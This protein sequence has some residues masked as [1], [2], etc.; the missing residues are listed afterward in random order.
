M[1]GGELGGCKETIVLATEPYTY[2]N[3]IAGMPNG[4]KTVYART[5][6]N[7]RAPRAGIIASLDVK[8]TAMDSWCNGDCAVAL[9][10]IGGQNTVVVSLYLDI[11]SSVQPDWLDDLMA[12]IDKKGYPVIIGVDS[13]AHSSLF[14]PDN[15]ARGNDFE[16]FV[17]QYGLNIENIGTKPTFEIRRGNQLVQTHIDVT[18]S[19]GLSA[20][21][22]RN[23]R[24]SQDYNASDHN[25]IL[26]EIYSKKPEP[27]LVRPWGKADWPLFKQTLSNANYRIPQDMSMK[28]LDQ[29]VDR[30][31]T[32]L[33]GALD[34]A[35]PIIQ[36]QPKIGN[37]HWATEKHDKGKSR[38]NDLYK[39]AKKTGSQAD[40]DAYK[41]ADKEFKRMC[42]NDKN[43]AWRKYKECI[44][45][46]KE[47]ASLAKQ[48]Q[49][50]ERRDINV[51]SKPD[52][53]ST[54]PGTETINLLTETH[55]PAATDTKHVTYN[56]RR[57]ISL[58]NL[59]TKYT[60]W[61]DRHK[62]TSALQGFEKKKS[63]GPDGLKPLVFEHLPNEFISTLE[64]IY[65]SAIHLGYM[66]K[67]W[68][69]T[70]VIFISKPGKESYDTPKSFRP[71]S[72]SNYLL[73]GLERLVGWRMDKAL[74]KY[75]IHEKQHGFLSGK[76]TESAIS[77][78]VNY[79]EKYVMTKQHCAGVFLDISAAFDSIKPGHVRQA[80][81]KHGG[82]PEMVQW[83]FNYITHRDIEITMH[84]VTRIFTTG[85]GFPQGGV[86]SAKFWLIAF[87][88]AIQ[89]INRYNIEGNGYADDCSAL[90]GGRR[91]DHALKKLQKMLDDLT[92]WGKTCGL[93]F[94]PD[95]S[96][97]VIF[98]RRH[99]IPPFKLKI[100]GKNIEYRTEVRYLGVLLD[101]KL[102]WKP[103]IEEKLIK[104]KQYLGKVANM[105]RNNWGPKPMLMRWAYIG[106]VRPMLCYGS[107]IWGHRAPEVMAKLRRINRMAI[108]TFANF[109][110][111]TPTTALEVMLD[112]K[113][114]HLFCIQEAL[115]A[116]VRLDRV[117]DFGWHGTSHT[118]NHAISHMG[119]LQNKMDLYGLDPQSVDKRSEVRWNHK[120]KINRDSFDGAAKHRRLSQLNVYTDGSKI[121]G[122]TG[123]GVTVY[124]GKKVIEDEHYKLPDGT[125]VFQAEVAAMAKAADLLLNRSNLEIRFV[126]IFVD[127]QAAIR[128]VGNNFISSNVVAMAIDNLNKLA[129][130]AKSVSIVWIPAHKGHEGNERADGL[131]KLGANSTDV[132][133]VLQI[134][135]PPATMKARIKEK[136]HEEW[137]EEW[138]R[139]NIAN[140][141][142]T[143]YEDLNVGKAKYVYKLARLELGRFVRIIT[144]H[145]NL[146]FFQT[147][148]GLQGDP[149]CRF[150]GEGGETLM[151]L[152]NKCPRFMSAREDIFLD[153]IPSR[154][155]KWSVRD[156]LDFSYTPGINEAYEGS[157]D[158]GDPPQVMED[159]LEDSLGLDWLEE[160]DADVTQV[161]QDVNNN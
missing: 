96:V 29:L 5:G 114:L 94:N 139:Q 38:V 108:N 63:P 156:L 134:K 37:S 111:S 101:S 3:V 36:V 76:S 118:K 88:Y 126:K 11:K 138:R 90:A 110:K 31:Y 23:W 55:F 77:N 33:E 41:L 150:C 46:E 69:R 1:L 103:H 127:S 92:E 34:A 153:Q 143:F 100:D 125:T 60:D 86:C 115:A 6:N 15:N 149:H 32:L 148:I 95:K 117:L 135:Q 84:G 102:H 43:K 104:T 16:D 7:G 66:P 59:Q 130:K 145:N 75:P 50:E 157:W 152:L 119:F 129:E 93:K 57:N 121:D 13:N 146:N 68:K 20:S 18:L 45:S 123:A 25:T 161:Q 2:N 39:K 136:V 52:G 65:K 42:R 58:D 9:M 67:A 62:I 19:R 140:H 14:G 51:L 28:K 4:T 56:N 137:L 105:T 116:R 142:K 49:R 99:K 27:E 97:A 72:L 91:L 151:H 147:K 132:D 107:M 22:I 141:T 44:Q 47:M 79:I 83:Y 21:A 8:L 109:P 26:F 64:V 85:I 112:I 12:M 17:L 128:A 113:P 40:W 158:T 70:K 80:L 53:S 144:G 73:K 71:I 131:A 61:I 155:V 24:V 54:D 87:D 122:H 160:P 154:G 133:R 98:T 120:F 89:I 78:T 48:A 81:L 10:K 74:E 30:T 35:C 124:D 159:G 82:D 106:I